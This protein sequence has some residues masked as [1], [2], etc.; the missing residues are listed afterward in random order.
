MGPERKASSTCG[1]GMAGCKS[2]RTSARKWTDAVSDPGIHRHL[3][4]RT[5]RAQRPRSQSG[6]THLH[7]TGNQ[8]GPIRQRAGPS[9]GTLTRMKSRWLA[10]LDQAMELLR[11]IENR[12]LFLKVHV[13]NALASLL[14]N[15][16]PRQSPEDLTISA[17]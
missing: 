8:C 9:A 2:F 15:A 12:I 14:E 11:R 17:V 13:R 5:G 10:E 16:T 7:H 6:G 3:Q 4:P 1:P